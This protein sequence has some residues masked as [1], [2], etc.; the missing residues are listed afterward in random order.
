ML[1]GNRGPELSQSFLAACAHTYG[2]QETLFP[3]PFALRSEA[4]QEATTLSC[5]P[6]LAAAKT[7][8]KNPRIWGK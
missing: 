5:C 8:V 1:V 6:I 2:L 3:R 4:Q 7:E